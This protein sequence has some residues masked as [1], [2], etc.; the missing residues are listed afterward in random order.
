MPSRQGTCRFCEQPTRL[1]KAHIIP[2]AFFRRLR[3]GDRAPLLLKQRAH[4]K[5][6]P[7]GIY[8]S[9]ILCADCDGLFA[10]WDEYAQSVLSPELDHATE[11]ANGTQVG[12]WT[13]PDYRYDLLKLFF[14][15]PL[16]RASISGHDFYRRIR[17][18]S[19]ESVAKELIA[20]ADP[21]PPEQFGVILARF[22]NPEATGIFD[23]HG[24]RLEGIKYCRF[25]MGRYVA[26]IK[27]DS[28]PPSGGWLTLSMK[29]GEP[30][31]IVAR[32]LQRSK[33]L[34]LMCE[35]VTSL[36]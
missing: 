20:K 26:Y 22:Q 33:E 8:D 13:I 12:G 2:E 35:I 25:Y 36:K 30:L 11:W 32:N 23:P 10:P 34:N 1:I 21:G 19:L 7:I 9:E 14:I 24:D 4:I 3:E 5:R 18:G 29:P 15:S 6:S 28:R 16:W 31:V 27:V 17:L